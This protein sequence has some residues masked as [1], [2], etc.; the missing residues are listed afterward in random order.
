MSSVPYDTTASW[1]WPKEEPI[2]QPIKEE[3]QEERDKLPGTFEDVDWEE[4][5]PEEISEEEIERETPKPQRH[6]SPRTCRICLEV[7]QPNYESFNSTSKFG[8]APKVTYI[9]ADPAD[10]RL[11]R[12][13]M[14]NLPRLAL[15]TPRIHRVFLGSFK[16]K[17]TCADFQKVSAKAQV[18]MYTK[19]VC[20]RGDM[21]IQA[22]DERTFGSVQPASSDIS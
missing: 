18:D 17:K 11:I 13:C 1:S 19:V 6:Y 9:S 5:H 10:G 15:T 12:P 16:I 4:V 20:S 8:P 22:M 21:R 3:M 2:V 14:S 7:V